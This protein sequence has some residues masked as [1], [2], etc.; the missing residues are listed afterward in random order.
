MQWTL[1]NEVD[2]KSQRRFTALTLDETVLLVYYIYV[3]VFKAFDR[4]R[5]AIYRWIESCKALLATKHLQIWTLCC[6]C[7]MYSKSFNKAR[8]QKRSSEPYHYETLHLREVFKN[9]S[10]HCVYGT[11][12]GQIIILYWQHIFHL[13]TIFFFFII[14]TKVLELR[15]I[16]PSV[17]RHLILH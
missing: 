5:P 4:A 2:Y 17:R 8:A 10:D 15:S 16:V 9:T 11:Y 3:S 14:I 12:W 6:L 13:N 7:K 1:V